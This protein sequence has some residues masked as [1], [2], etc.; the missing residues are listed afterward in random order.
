MLMLQRCGS[1]LFTKFSVQ[2]IIYHYRFQLYRSGLYIR[3]ELH[4]VPCDFVTK[5]DPTYPVILGGVLSN[6]TSMGFLKVRVKRHRWFKR[7]LK[8]LYQLTT[9]FVSNLK[10]N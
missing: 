1:V 2:A 10:L 7:I 4:D 9:S 3:A 6:E 8:V 5:F